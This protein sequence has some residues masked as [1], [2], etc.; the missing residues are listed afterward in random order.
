MTDVVLISPYEV[1]RQPFGLS[2][3]A[4]WLEQAGF[5]VACLDLSIQRLDPPVLKQARLVGIH[6]AMHTATRIAVEALPCIRAAAPQAHICAYGLYAPMNFELLRARGVRTVL[7]GECE[8]DLLALARRVAAGDRWDQTQ[9]SVNLTKIAFLT[10]SRSSLPSLGRYAKLLVSGGG[11]KTMGFVEA[12]RGCKHLCRHC[13]VVPVYGG[14][15]RIV[16]V[17]VVL[18]DIRNQV[19]VGAQHVSFG[20]PDF[21][22]GP[23]HAKRIVTALHEA[24]PELTYDATIKIQHIVNSRDMLPLLK[25]TG[26]LFVTSAAEAVDDEIL[27]YLGKNHT[28]ADFGLAVKLTRQAGIALAP[29]FVAFTPWISLEGYLALLRRLVELRLVEAVPPIQLAIRLLIPEGS[30]M[31][32]L[33]GF[34][35]FLEPFEPHILGYPWRHPDPRIDVLHAEIVRLV[36][37]ADEKGLTRRTTFEEIWRVAHATLNRRAPDLPA[38]LGSEIPRH[39]E[40]WYCCAEPTKQQLHAF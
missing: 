40:A 1:G 25:E 6:L 10:P 14:H 19:A 38:D 11:T 39:S 31:L 16:P 26:C 33:P 5:S 7:G 13:P 4:A 12:S 28:D 37:T 24:F 3:P 27:R 20:D 23:A 32:E 36:E 8:P 35:D 17:D 21:L 15:F 2:Q 30:R 22:N 9:P 29:T 18:E 34:R